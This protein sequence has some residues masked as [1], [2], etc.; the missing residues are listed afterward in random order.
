MNRD[1]HR[2]GSQQLVPLKG[3][4]GSALLP[5]VGATEDRHLLPLPMIVI[6][7]ASMSALLAQDPPG[8][9]AAD[10]KIPWALTQSFILKKNTSYWGLRTKEDPSKS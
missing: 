10:T 1:Q 3:P 7:Q 2:A 5:E 6:L 4:W 9:L 8:V